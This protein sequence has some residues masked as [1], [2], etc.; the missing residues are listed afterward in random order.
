MSKVVRVDAS[1]FAVEGDMLFAD[2]HA[3]RA[4][5]EAL[6]PTL[7]SPVTVDLAA[8]EGVGSVGVSV[9]LCWMRAA[10]KL[11]KS[12]IFVNMPER[13]YDVSR[14]SGLDEVIPCSH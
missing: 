10:E 2:A 3:L 13:M 6:L 9:L 12:L 1:R 14:V 5:G 4:A 11:G 7:T 8:V